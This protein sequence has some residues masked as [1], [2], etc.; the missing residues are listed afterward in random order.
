MS[1]LQ[2]YYQKIV[3]QDLATKFNYSNIYQIPAIK[4]V[5]LSFKV[6]HYSLKHIVPLV[7]ALTLISYQKPF[8]IRS[9]QTN[10]VLKL[11][12]G[13]PIGCMV[14]IQKKKMYS[15]LERFLFLILPQIKESKEPSFKIGKNNIFF[16]LENLYLYKE[17]EKQYENFQDLPE[18]NVLIIV[19]TQ[20]KEEITSLLSA[21]KF[22]I[23]ND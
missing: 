15:F 1:V 3:K 13:M 22:P 9:R 21:L 17:I 14:T 12:K 19:N 7:S 18:L 20:K 16:S 8:F 11:R 2:Y 23:K 10:L 5:C 4:K 6:S